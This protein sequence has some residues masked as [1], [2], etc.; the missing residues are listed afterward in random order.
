MKLYIDLSNHKFMVKAILE[1]NT[2]N[3]EFSLP[4]TLMIKEL[5]NNSKLDSFTKEEITLP[6]MPKM[7][8]YSVTD[9]DNGILTIDYSGRL[10]SYFYFRQEEIIHF[11]FYNA[12]YPVI[13]NSKEQYEI[14][15]K[16][17]PE[18]FLINGDFDNEKNVWKYNTAFQTSLVDPNIILLNK[19]YVKSFASDIVKA[20]YFDPSRDSY[21][22]EYVSEYSKIHD[23]FKE[24]YENDKI[25]FSNVVFLPPKYHAGGYKRDKLI[26]FSEFDEDF[27]SQ[28]HKTAH[29]MAHAYAQGASV[30]TYED[31]LNE[32]N[33][34][35]SALLFDLKYNKDVFTNKIKYYLDNYGANSLYLKEKDS[36]KR[37]S[38][39]V[40]HFAGVIIYY[41]IYL[42]YGEE[43]IRKMLKLFDI[44]EEKTTE[45]LLNSFTE[46]GLGDIAKILNTYF[47]KK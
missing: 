23:F 46:N 10:S 9:I 1:V 20:Y 24:L 30:Y 44:L 3:F 38:S 4:K 45:Q 40:V 5:H 33:A 25:T 6:Y 12:Y 42:K 47:D 29:E 21:V 35:W 31:W 32:T 41:N 28:M 34:E 37:P 22:S 7:Y 26:V 16:V 11:S 17:S 8:K 27:A 13:S 15:I 2:S 18:Y 39:L 14:E 43:V 36:D 19:N